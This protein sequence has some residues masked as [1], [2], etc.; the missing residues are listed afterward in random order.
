M[1]RETCPQTHSYICSIANLTGLAGSL[2]AGPLADSM[3]KHRLLLLLISATATSALAMGGF[4]LTFM[5]LEIA[6]PLPAS[7]RT[8]FIA[9]VGLGSGISLPGVFVCVC[10][11]VCLCVCVHAS[12]VRCI[13]RSSRSGGEGSWSL[14]NMGRRT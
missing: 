1:P 2:L 7:F 9:L 5:P 13:D 4:V 10:V 8:P 14:L 11:C 6:P 3:F 12:L